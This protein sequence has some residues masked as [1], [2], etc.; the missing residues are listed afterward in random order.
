MM[1]M[2]STA[3]S[4]SPQARPLIGIQ[5][6]SVTLGETPVLRDLDLVIREGELLAIVGPSGCGKST[7]LRVLLGLVPVSPGG[8]VQRHGERAL[9]IVFQ[10]PTLMPWRTARANVELCMQLGATRVTDRADRARRATRA[11][12]LVGL[13]GFEEHY[14]HELSGGMQ[15]RVAIARALVVGPSLLLMDEPFGALDELTR[16]TM[17]Q[18]LLRLLEHS[19]TTLKTVVLVT[20]SIREALLLA[21]RVVVLSAR[22]AAVIASF[23]PA[24]GK[25]RSDH[26]WHI[27]GT[28]AFRR[29]LDAVRSKLQ[30]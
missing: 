28:P 11:L 30:P 27:E 1:I 18:E 20:H 16:S 21:D 19:E 4:P 14:P 17:N 25:P 29:A 7:L 13:S 5:R 24:F 8:H 9:G 2:P 3:P 15:Q 10:K 23:E 22:P 12:G 26:Y 6:C